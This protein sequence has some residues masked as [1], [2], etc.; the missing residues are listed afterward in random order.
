MFLHTVFLNT[1]IFKLIC[2][3]RSWDPNRYYNSDLSGPGSNGNKWVS[4]LPKYPELE[5]HNQ[6]QLSVIS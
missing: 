4:T 3:I 6:M 1:N 5:P 2:L